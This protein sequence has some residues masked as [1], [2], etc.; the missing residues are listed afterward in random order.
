MALEQLS[1]LLLDVRPNNYISFVYS[2]RRKV[3]AMFYLSPTLTTL[4]LTVVPPVSLGAV[5][6][7]MLALNHAS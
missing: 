7:H 1:W 4:M 3:G 2:K 5:S 6:L